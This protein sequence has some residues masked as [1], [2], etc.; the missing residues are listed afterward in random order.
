MSINIKCYNN[1]T[2]LCEY[3]SMQSLLT[4]HWMAWNCASIWMCIHSK[5]MVVT[6]AY[7]HTHTH[8]YF[9]IYICMY[10]SVYVR[11]HVLFPFHTSWVYYGIRTTQYELNNAFEFASVVYKHEYT[12]K[13]VLVKW[14]PFIYDAKTTY[15]HTQGHAYVYAEIRMYMYVCWVF[16]PV[17]PVGNIHH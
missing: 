2:L 3:L 6:I 14:G 9:C 16:R 13:G 12:A 5:Q 7:E 4:T 10:V 8:S 11:V 15:L 17:S 1:V